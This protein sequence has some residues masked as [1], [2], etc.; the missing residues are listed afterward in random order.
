VLAAIETSPGVAANGLPRWH[1][2]GLLI[3]YLAE[4]PAGALLETC[5]HTS[6]NDVP[7]DYRLLEVTAEEPITIDTVETSVLKPDWIE[8]PDD[9]R[10][11]GSAWAALFGV[12][13]LIRSPHAVSRSS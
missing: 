7:R 12:S 6:A 5:V 8:H 3:V 2:S 4:S 13:P 9:T 10:E 11:I 1:Q